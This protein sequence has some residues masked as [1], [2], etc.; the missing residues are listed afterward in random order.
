MTPPEHLPPQSTGA[1][2]QQL[3]QYLR[4]RRFGHDRWSAAEYAGLPF[5]EA[6]LI[7]REEGLA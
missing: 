1:G 3:Q 7:D 5:G 4:A 2:S 6:E